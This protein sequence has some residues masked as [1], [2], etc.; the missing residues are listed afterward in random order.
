MMQEYISIRLIVGR[1]QEEKTDFPLSNMTRHIAFVCKAVFSS[2]GARWL[3]WLVNRGYPL[4]TGYH[5]IRVTAV[6]LD[7]KTMSSIFGF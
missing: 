2:P 6:Q 5:M 1:A 7:D 4:P 3:G